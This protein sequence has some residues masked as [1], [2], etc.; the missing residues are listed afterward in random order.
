LSKDTSD[1]FS[2]P[3]FWHAELDTILS[4]DPSSVKR[5]GLFLILFFVVRRASGSCRGRG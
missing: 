5:V 1:S 3:F 2:Q 4:A